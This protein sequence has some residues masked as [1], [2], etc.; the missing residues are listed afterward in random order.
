LEGGTNAFGTVGLNT[1]IQSKIATLPNPGYVY[2]FCVANG[3]LYVTSNSDNV[4]GH[5]WLI[6][7]AT[8]QVSS[9]G[10]SGIY[11]YSLGSTS[12]GLFGE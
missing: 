3:N 10:S 9:V 1:G 11:Y 12:N 4:Y 6:N 2:S 7:P 8:G 5:P